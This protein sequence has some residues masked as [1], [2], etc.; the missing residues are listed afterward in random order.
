[1]KFNIFAGIFSYNKSKLAPTLHGK[2]LD[3]LGVM[4]GAGERVGLFDYLTLFIT[5][6]LFW[7]FSILTG[8]SIGGSLLILDRPILGI[9]LSPLSFLALNISVLIVVTLQVLRFSTSYMASFLLLPIITLIHLVSVLTTTDFHN[10]LGEKINDLF[11]FIKGDEENPGLF[12][13]L[14]LLFKVPIDFFFELSKTAVSLVASIPALGIILLPISIPMTI[15]SGLISGIYYSVRY[16]VSLVLTGLTLPL[17]T[18]AHLV[19]DWRREQKSKHWISNSIKEAALT[20]D[21]VTITSPE[22]LPLSFD[23]TLTTHLIEE[24]NT[25]S[26]IREINL[27]R[28][29]NLYVMNGFL[30]YL[31]PNLNHVK[32]VKTDHTCTNTTLAI[33][34]QS[35]IEYLTIN[36]SHIGQHDLFEF[37]KQNKNVAKLNIVDTPN[38]NKNASNEF[39]ALMQSEGIKQPC[40][41]DCAGIEAQKINTLMADISIVHLMIKNCFMFFKYTGDEDNTNFIPFDIRKYITGFLLLISPKGILELNKKG[42]V[43]VIQSQGFFSTPTKPENETKECA[44]LMRND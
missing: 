13:H 3:T 4:T 17:V 33:I 27:P 5:I 11:L 22:E 35:N 41:I 14:T 7:A 40:L 9:F 34:A 21:N 20:S 2:F 44:T 16:L 23:E 30:N 32:R 10:S 6:P 39:K 38:L 1:M 42:F 12:D 28:G 43:S 36:A 29:N 19:L 15:T 25:H 37:L 26:T 31:I 8:F 18:L 24:L